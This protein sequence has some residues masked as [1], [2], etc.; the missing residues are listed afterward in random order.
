MLKICT[1][2]K[3]EKDIGEFP[4]KPKKQLSV[5]GLKIPYQSNC[6]KCLSERQCEWQRRNKEKYNKSR[7]AWHHRQ[8][9]NAVYKTRKIINTK[10]YINKNNKRHQA[11]VKNYH[12]RK[13]N[14]VPP[15]LSDIQHEQMR[16]FYINCPKGMHVD[17]IVPLRG[18]TVSGLHVPWNL[19]Y[20]TAIE[21]SRKGN[22]LL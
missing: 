18:K 11:H 9:N 16:Q 14:R 20:L 13:E 2:C 8:K 17:H 21:N 4:L 12:L 7:L 10:T 3:I 22:K 15:W 19:Q 1:R 6:K 5:P